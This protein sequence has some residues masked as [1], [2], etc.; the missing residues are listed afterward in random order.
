MLNKTETFCASFGIARFMIWITHLLV[1]QVTGQGF[2]L[3]SAALLSKIATRKSV[4]SLVLPQLLLLKE[5]CSF[6]IWARQIE[7]QLVNL[8]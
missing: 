2:L 7:I 1:L 8:T 5:P 4:S 3:D 6:L